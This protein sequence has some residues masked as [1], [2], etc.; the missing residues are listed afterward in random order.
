MKYF[1]YKA[2]NFGLYL[3]VMG[4]QL[5]FL[6]LGFVKGFRKNGI[7]VLFSRVQHFY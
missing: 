3:W 2:K 4:S 7:Y 5:V 1:E 6:N